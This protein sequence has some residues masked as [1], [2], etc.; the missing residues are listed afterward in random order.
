MKLLLFAGIFAML[1]GFQNCA[2]TQFV[3]AAVSADAV[4]APTEPTAEAG[5]AEAAPQASN[6]TPACVPAGT[7]LFASSTFIYYRKCDGELERWI[8]LGR[9]HCCSGEV[10][11]LDVETYEDAQ[12]S[13][14]RFAGVA[15]CE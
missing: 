7:K 15:Y 4:S 11:I 14:G 1:V 6:Q 5:A 8:Q 2:P 9:Q 12:C 3:R 13:D 10:T